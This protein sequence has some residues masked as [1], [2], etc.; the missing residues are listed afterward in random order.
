MHLSL[1][2]IL[3][4]SLF[5]VPFYSS[6][7]SNILPSLTSLLYSVT[8]TAPLSSIF[9]STD[10]LPSTCS[11]ILPHIQIPIPIVLYPYQFSS[12]LLNFVT[13]ITPFSSM[14]SLYTSFPSSYTPI[15]SL[16]S[17]RPFLFHHFIVILLSPI[18]F[19]LSIHN[20]LHTHNRPIFCVI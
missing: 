13:S 6:L 16:Q 2:F 14:L 5:F 11:S 17:K 1:L 18:L 8:S 7:S 9:P 12:S 10:P 4:F 20:S 15:P 19:L 3:T